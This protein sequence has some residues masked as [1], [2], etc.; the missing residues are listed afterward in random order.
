MT[1]H[2]LKHRPIQSDETARLPRDIFATRMSR[3]VVGMVLLWIVPTLAA[4]RSATS[5]S[6]ASSRP[7][8][9][10][11]VRGSANPETDLKALMQEI[12]DAWGTLDPANAARFYAKEPNNV[13]YDMT[14]LKYTGWAEYV[15]GVKKV[16]GDFSSQRLTL[17]DDART[18]LHGSLAWATAT[19]HGDVVTKSGAKKTL[20]GR[21]TVVWERKGKEWLIVHE[22]VS[23]PLPPADPA[24]PK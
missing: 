23:L 11:S 21:W 8:T 19:W 13:F 14:P 20:I 12:L 24:T 17:G 16:I 3:I 22:H 10:V 15:E 1:N 9:N 5:A 4:G 2:S 7:R 18:H 6:P